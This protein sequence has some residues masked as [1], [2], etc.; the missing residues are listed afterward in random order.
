MEE[1]YCLCL[2]PWISKPE[3]TPG[4]EQA[5]TEGAGG[6]VSPRG[7]RA[8][9]L[10]PTACS[11]VM[12][13]AARIA[14]PEELWSLARKPA[15]REGVLIIYKCPATVLSNHVFILFITSG[16]NIAERNP[17]F[18]GKGPSITD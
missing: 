8:L 13:G 1:T 4:C 14:L 5:G 3:E 18:Y 17:V 11:S 9:A 2:E 6:E 12:H 7:D 16:G 10:C 15:L